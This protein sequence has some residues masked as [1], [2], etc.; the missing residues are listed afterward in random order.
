M[1]S[2]NLD[3]IIALS[4]IAMNAVLIIWFLKNLASISKTRMAHMMQRIGLGSEII[5]LDDFRIRKDIKDMRSRCLRC[6]CDNYCD[7][8][9]AGEVTGENTFCA[10]APAFKRWPQTQSLA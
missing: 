2:T 9:L 7:R 1:N 6:S 10:N 4:M 3:I 5:S 8:W